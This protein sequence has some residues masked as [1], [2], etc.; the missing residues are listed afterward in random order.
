[1]Q[2]FGGSGGFL[3]QCRI[4]LRHGVHLGDG[5]IDLLDAGFLL[6]AGSSDLALKSLST[7]AFLENFYRQARNRQDGK[8]F[9]L[10]GPA[11]LSDRDTDKKL[12][13]SSI[14]A[15]KC[16]NINLYK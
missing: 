2:R 16:R 7:Q 4:L 15:D 14:D 3:H 5:L 12:C 10:T 11:S 6:P 9:W 8:D 13:L 1:M